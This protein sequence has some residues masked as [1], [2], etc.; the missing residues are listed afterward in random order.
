MRGLDCL[1]HSFRVVPIFAMAEDAQCLLVER[2]KGRLLHQS[3]CPG[4]VELV[5]AVCYRPLK[6][7]LT[8]HF[9]AHVRSQANALPET[10]A[11]KHCVTSN[12]W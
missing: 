6:D 12:G 1:T 9:S 8:T 4:S 11:P 5:T 10:L 3:C 7:S 2:R